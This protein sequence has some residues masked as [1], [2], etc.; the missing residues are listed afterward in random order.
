MSTRNVFWICGVILILIG[1]AW[2]GATI[3]TMGQGAV[4]GPSGPPDAS[5]SAGRDRFKAIL[6][7]MIVIDAGI[8]AVVAGWLS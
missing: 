2:M 4:T 8:L 6:K 5:T 3:R 7:P 1:S